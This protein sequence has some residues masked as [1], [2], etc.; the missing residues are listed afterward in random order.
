[1]VFQRHRAKGARLLGKKKNGPQVLGTPVCRRRRRRLFQPFSMYFAVH[2]VALVAAP[3]GSF[4]S[5]SLMLPSPSGEDY[6]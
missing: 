1:M 6:S 4:V 2:R 3:K 5:Y